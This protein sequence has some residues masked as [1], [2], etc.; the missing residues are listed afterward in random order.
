MNARSCCSPALPSPQQTSTPLVSRTRQVVSPPAKMSL[1][2]SQTPVVHIAEMPHAFPHEPQF[3][4]SS[5]T[6]VSHPFATPPEQ[7]SQLPPV[8]LHAVIAHEP[9][10]HAQLLTMSA[11]GG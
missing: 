6:S 1:I 4:V 9:A 2:P 5:S 8:P 10:T 7:S 11:A 3:A